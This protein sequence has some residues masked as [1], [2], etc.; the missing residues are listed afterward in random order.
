M[1]ENQ[2]YKLGL[3]VNIDHFA[4]IRQARLAKY[5]DPIAIASLI[6]HSGISCITAHLREDRRHIQDNDMIKI[7]ENSKEK[8]F[9]VNME[10]AP[11]HEMFEFACKHKPYQVTICPEKRQELS[12]ESGLNVK[13][14][15]DVLTEN[16]KHLH[17]NNIKVSLFVD[18]DR[19]M[20]DAAAH[21]GADIIE[22]H[23]GPYANAANPRLKVEELIKLVDASK[24]AHKVHK[25]KVNAGHGL[26]YDNVYGM[27]M[28]P[29][30]NELNIGHSIVARSTFV[31]VQEAVNEMLEI[32][33]KYQGNQTNKII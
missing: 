7:I 9:R 19:S 8:N 4:T 6:W 31:G 15:F 18:T 11:T 30:L 21:V 33:I 2:K 16:I 13:D 24:Y 20:I 26:D 23:T 5:P 10:M 27:F 17:H 32:L 28:V 14:Y 12:T 1:S 25:L 22:L 29:Y 3:G